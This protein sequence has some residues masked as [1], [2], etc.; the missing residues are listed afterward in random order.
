MWVNTQ[1]KYMKQ[2]QINDQSHRERTA[3]AGCQM[4]IWEKEI[5]IEKCKV[6]HMGEA[7]SDFTLGTEMTDS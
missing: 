4:L 7:N 6:M 1:L 5:N 3:R 2:Q